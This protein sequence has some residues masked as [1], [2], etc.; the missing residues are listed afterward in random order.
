MTPDGNFPSNFGSELAPLIHH[1]DAHQDS[2]ALPCDDDEPSLE[3]SLNE[4][5][6]AEFLDRIR[7]RSWGFYIFVTHYDNDD[8]GR[9]NLQAV[10]DKL[11]E[12][13]RLSLEFDVAR[14]LEPRP[15][16]DEVFARLRFEIVEDATTLANATVDRVRADLIAL[17]RAR[18]QDFYDDSIL[19]PRPV[20]NWTC[21]FLDAEAF[22][23]LK[24]AN[25][26]GP[27]EG[28]SR[29]DYERLED[30]VRLKF[31]D[32]CWKRPE[33]S[34]SAYR[35]WITWSAFCLPRLYYGLSNASNSGAMEDLYCSFK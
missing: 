22:Q 7:D 4:E 20:R 2:F 5:E 11:V 15:F 3:E 18:R 23:M 25:W 8:P 29:L 19:P 14:L 27:S 24:D 9:G 17:V 21:L 32:A 28:F 30:L 31:V 34:R 16:T 26:P 1:I 12:L 33:R 6:F 13:V 10:L 35:G